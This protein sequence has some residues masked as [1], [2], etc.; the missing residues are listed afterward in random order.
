MPV[1]PVLTPT[2]TD[3]T[4]DYYSITVKT[5]TAQMRPGAPT[6]IV[7][8]N[9]VFPGPT[10]VAEKGRAVHVTQTNG[11]TENI[12]IHNHGHKAAESSDGHPIDYVTP[13]SS[14]TYTYPNDQ[15]AATYWYHDHT[16]DLAGPHIYHGLAGFYLIHDKAEDA[17]KLPSGKYD[18]PLLVQDKYLLDDNT[19]SYST[20][21]I[22]PGFIGTQGFV[23]GALTPHFDVD[24]HKY[25]FRV[26]NAATARTFH[27]GLKSGKSFQVIA[28]DGGLLS[29]PVSVTQLSVSPSERY[30]I[31]VDFSQSAVG[32]TD[33]L[34]NSETTMP[35]ISTLVEF[36]VK[37]A[38]TDDSAVPAT[39]AQIPKLQESQSAGT[40]TWT[41]SQDFSNGTTWVINGLTYDPARLDV[42]SHQGSVY[43]W[44][45]VNSS[46]FL[47]P[48]HK[49]LTQFQILDIDGKAPPPE[50]SGWKDTVPVG[51]TS[52]VRIIFANQTFTGKY[53]F[54]CHI[55]E[56]EDH[57]MML[58]ESVVS[59]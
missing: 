13:G 8:F 20:A 5:G 11:W 34:V 17:L 52:T 41:F 48:F 40:S 21:T 15:N 9:G 24:T 7:G 53:V 1:P 12:T 29:A 35:T 18:V 51:V 22:G 58:Q 59:P 46:N 57:R 43:V 39:L 56:H 49:H 25:R 23:N 44:K 14:K 3:A 30:D 19:L 26:L 33:T 10:I 55:T 4:T 47:H 28:S 37:N 42:V 31:I 27:I 54:H 6:P 2:S 50:M 16:M 38:V 45:L 36:R 32:T